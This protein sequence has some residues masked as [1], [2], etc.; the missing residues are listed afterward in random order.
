MYTCCETVTLEGNVVGLSADG[1]L[2][3]C[4]FWAA[5]EAKCRQGERVALNPGPPFGDRLKLEQLIAA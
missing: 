3:R 5:V 4:R 1:A 2:R